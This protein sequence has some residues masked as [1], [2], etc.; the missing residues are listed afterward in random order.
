ML[1]KAHLDSL[2]KA[3]T[4]G[5]QRDFLFPKL[6]G[7][8]NESCCVLNCNHCPVTLCCFNLSYTSLEITRNRRGIGLHVWLDTGASIHNRFNKRAIWPLLMK[9][10]TW[11]KSKGLNLFTQ[12]SLAVV[13]PVLSG[14]V[15]NHKF[16]HKSSVLLLKINCAGGSTTNKMDSHF[17][18]QTKTSS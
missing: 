16:Y 4:A 9:P 11:E 15:Q 3:W 6:C 12:H 8:K 17:N 5:P 7:S 2:V 1:T 10:N 18:K 14:S 13:N